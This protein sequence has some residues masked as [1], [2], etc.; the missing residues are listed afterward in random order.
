M[1]TKLNLSITALCLV[2]I[3]VVYAQKERLLLMLPTI[4]KGATTPTTAAAANPPAAAAT[5]N[6]INA[7]KQ[8]AS[9]ADLSAMLQAFDRILGLNEVQ[10]D[11]INHQNEKAVERIGNTRQR[12]DVDDAWKQRE[13]NRLQLFRDNLVERVLTPKQ[14]EKWQLFKQT[15]EICKS[16]PKLQSNYDLYATGKATFN[17]LEESKEYKTVADMKAHIDAMQV[18]LKRVAMTT[19]EIQ[20]MQRIIYNF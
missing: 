9:T 18:T 10:K 11:E 4:S 13:I 15:V 19:E 7:T 12:T 3:T 8:L 2:A 6:A 16:L 1:I 5:N 17:K 14:I 20:D